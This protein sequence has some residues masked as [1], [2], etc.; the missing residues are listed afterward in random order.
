MADYYAQAMQVPPLILIPNEVDTAIWQT[1][2][3]ERA[4]KRVELR[5]PQ[6][7]DKLE[8][9]GMAER[10]AVTGLEAELALLEKRGEAPGVKELQQLAELENP[11]YRI[12]GYDISNLMG[13]HTTASIVVFEGGPRPQERVQK[14]ADHRLRAA[15]RLLLDAPGDPA[16]FYRLLVR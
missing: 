4:K 10:N 1:F 16:P 13:T 6:R 9:M 7:G 15:R 11:P 2:L 3:S 5:V 12:E 14:N 8:L